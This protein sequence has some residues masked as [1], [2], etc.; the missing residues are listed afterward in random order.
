MLK[1]VTSDTLTKVGGADRAGEKKHDLSACIFTTCYYNY[2]PSPA[3]PVIPM[4]GTLTALPA[5][6]VA[7]TVMV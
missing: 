1:E 2:S 5:A 6:L 4:T 7:V 3:S